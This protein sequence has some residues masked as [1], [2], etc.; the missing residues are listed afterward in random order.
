MAEQPQGTVSL[1]FTDIEGS[2]R[3]LQELGRERYAQALD[4][5]RRLLRE[6]F[7]RHGG[8][9]VDYEGDAFFIAFQSAEQAVDAASQAQRA[10]A[11]ADWPDQRAI[12]VRIGIHTGE[13]GLDP[14]KYVG[15]DVHKAARIMSAGHGGQVL[16]SQPT[17]ELLNGKFALRDLGEHR[18]KDFEEL[19][20][21]YQLGEEPFPPLKT[22]SNTN[23]PRPASSFIGREEE[24]AEIVALVR[25]GARLITLTGAG[26]SGKTRLAIEAAAE[27]VPDFANGVFWVGLAT[28]R[29]PSLVTTT[30]AQTLGGKNGLSEHIAERELLLL[31]DNFEQVVKAARELSQLLS[32]CPNLSLIVTSR[33]LLRIQGEVEQPVPPLPEADSVALFCARSRLEPSAAI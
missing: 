25:G 18:L 5:H 17:C 15:I 2:T 1:L 16:L 7:E 26:G 14:P 21:L 28:L 10:L 6:A 29:D 4:L 33:E 3:L 27:V 24:A 12:R 31:L 8:Y 32:A 20:W 13:P 11:E 23:L 22:I 9:E 30:I 19:V